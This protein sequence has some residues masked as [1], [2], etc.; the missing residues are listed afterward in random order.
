MA[1][2]TRADILLMH[3]FAEKEPT[4]LLFKRFNVL[5]ARRIPYAGTII[6]TVNVEI[7]IEGRTS[8]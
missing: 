5:P 2:S 1:F 7:D 3:S 4:R 8:L 6:A